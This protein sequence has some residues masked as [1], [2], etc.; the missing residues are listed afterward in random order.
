LQRLF[1]LVYIFINLNCINFIFTHNRYLLYI[2]PPNPNALFHSKESTLRI[3]V[4]SLI[5]HPDHSG[6]ALYSS[7]FAFYAA[8]QG[9]EVEVITG[10]PFYPKW[11][12]RKEDRY[13]LF[14]TETVKNVKIR[15]GYIYVPKKPTTVK[16]VLQEFTFLAS[17]CIN[18]FR[19]KKPDVIVSFTTPISIGYLSSLYKRIRGC[20]SVINVQDFQ[21]EA[22]DSLDMAKGSFFFSILAG[23]ERKSYAKSELVCSISNSMRDLLLH[24]KNL[25]ASKVYLW[26]NWIEVASYK[27]DPARKG[28][29]KKLHNIPLDKKIISYAGNVGL[30]QGLEIFIDL[31]IA[32]EHREDLVFM[33]VGEGARKAAIEQYAKDKGTKNVIMLPLSDQYL[34]FLNDLDIFFLPQK[35]TSFDVYFP[36]KLLGL[37]AAQKMLILSADTESELYKTIHQQELGLVANYG[38]LEELKHLLDIALNDHTIAERIKQNAT[39][40][41]LQFDRVPVLD[42]ALERMK[43]L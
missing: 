42:G 12:K 14:S 8:E 32:Y 11:Q 29:F 28:I 26:P 19:A 36:S 17:A 3:L 43:Q 23:M 20:K 30:K 2:S 6:I 9:H 4:T 15:R 40:Y 39:K 31:A 27:L 13:K 34:D 38:D 41:A 33:V 25:T 10:Y 18:M 5:F 1:L 7:D 21:L 35:K 37:M 16:R 24:K 22:A